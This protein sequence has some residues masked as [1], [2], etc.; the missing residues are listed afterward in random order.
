MTSFINDKLVVEMQMGL[1]AEAS[2]IKCGEF[3]KKSSTA[4]KVWI[5]RGYC[6][7]TRAYQFDDA[8][9]ISNCFYVANKKNKRAKAL[10]IGFTY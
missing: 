1:W 4:K 9:D 10:F 6:R 7:I 8:E 5:A 2:K 3:V